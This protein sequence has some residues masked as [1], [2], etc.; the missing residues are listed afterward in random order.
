M[1]VS[2]KIDRFLQDLSSLTNNH[3]PIKMQSRKE[4]KLKEKLWINNRIQKMNT[5]LFSVFVY[6][7]NFPY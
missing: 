6:C 2:K 7:I 3:A 4:M 5:S 1:D